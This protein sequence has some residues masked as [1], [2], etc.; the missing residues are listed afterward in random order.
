MDLKHVLLVE[1]NQD[2]ELLT[3]RS[4]QKSGVPVEIAV[5]HDG[6]EAYAYLDQLTAATLPCLVLL[7][8]KL[9]KVNGHEV[10][11]RIRENE[12]TRH[13]P[14]VVFTSSNEGLDIDEAYRRCCNSYVRKP[15]DFHLFS[16]A[17]QQICRYWLTVNIFSPDNLA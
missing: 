9:P 5:V 3:V 16:E 13:V 12:L 7:D 10:L 8:L 6:V 14:V 2:D 11:Q 17:V 15:V 4:I 1:D